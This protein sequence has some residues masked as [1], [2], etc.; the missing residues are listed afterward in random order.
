MNKILIIIQRE[1]LSRVMNKRFLLTTILTPLIMVG[2]IAGAALLSTSGKENHKI[3]VIDENGF[4]K[5][6]LRDAGDIKFEFPANVDTSNYV[7]KGYTDI[8]LIPKFEGTNKT[9]Y[10]IRSK[11]RIGL[12]LQSKIEDRINDAIEDQM[13]QDAGI[14]RAQLDSIKASSQFAEMKSLEEAGDTVKESSAALSYGIGFG[15]GM[16]I[17][18]TMFIYGAMVMRGV[19]E[20]KTNRIAEVMISSAKPFQ[21]MMGKIIGI[22]AVG[23]TQF[24][25][26]ILL[27]FGFIAASRFFI[28]QDVLQ[29]VAELQKTNAQMGPGASMAQASE[30][31]QNIYKFQNTMGTA[32]WPLIIGC[33]IFYFLGGYLFYA[34][35][36][37]AVGSVVNEDPQD[38]QSLMLPITMPIIF[39]FIIMS[40]A[41]EDPSTSLATWASIIPFSSPMVM[42]ARIA[43]G[44]PGT[45]PYWQ[46]IA[47]M[48]TLIGSFLLTTWLSGKVYR[49]GILMY[50]KKV[51]WK[52]IGKW[53]FRKN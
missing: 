45:V 53:A 41:V 29:Q 46:L 38:A 35:L 5:G 25:V 44:V 49:T 18:I 27:I 16:L 22:G 28:P 10:I 51:G 20:E 3:A 4:F 43:Y 36:F 50:G 15:S 2:V 1:Y 40:R 11:K 17:Y 13:L 7:S 34:S 14:N 42:M 30:T 48:A 33:F 21:L 8:I 47:S 6:N 52:E 26:W 12:M 39:S 23:L 19:M 32:N 37:A 31:A 24:F 9:T